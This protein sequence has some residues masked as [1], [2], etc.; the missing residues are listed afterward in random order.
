MEETL[1]DILLYI[2]RFVFG[3]CETFKNVAKLYFLRI[4]VQFGIC[5]TELVFLEISATE[6][7]NTTGIS[8]IGTRSAPEQAMRYSVIGSMSIFVAIAIWYFMHFVYRNDKDQSAV[9]HK[10]LMEIVCLFKVMEILIDSLFV[11]YAAVL[12]NDFE[13]ALPFFAIPYGN[14]NTTAWII[15]LVTFIDIL[16]GAVELIYAVYKLC[17][18][19]SRTNPV[20][21]KPPEIPDKKT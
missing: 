7:M 3:G 6:Q 1:P 15:S 16:F 17:K 11:A 4:F 12:Y 20:D 5:L 19:P 9:P 21:E 10:K 18:K 13:V 8:D 2:F 14:V